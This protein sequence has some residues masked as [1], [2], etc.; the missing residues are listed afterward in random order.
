MGNT[1]FIKNVWYVAGWS[2][3]LAPGERLSRTFLNKPVVLWR[4]AEGKVSA[5]EDR[6][7]HRAMPLSE[8]FVDGEVIRCPYHGMEFGADGR[9]VKIP[10]Q[11]QIP[12]A[13][14][15]VHFPLVEHQALLWIWMGDPDKADPAL[16]PDYPWHD[17]PQWAWRST[18]MLVKGNWQLLVDNLMDLSHLPYIHARTIGGNPELHFGTPTRSEKTPEGVR[19]TRRMPGSVPPP[20][21]VDAKGFTGLVDRWQEIAFEP[22]L[23]RIHTGA[24]DAGTGAYDGRRDHGLSMRGFHAITPETERTTHYFWSIATNVLDNGTPGKVYEQ[25]AATFREDLT[26][27][28]LQQI[29]NDAEPNRPMLDIASDV[30][31]RHARQVIARLLREEAA[32]P[33]HAAPA[34]NAP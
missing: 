29:R 20:T 28:E 3:E 13:A 1:P 2:S 19:V 32:P 26:V 14:K 34:G 23:V 12:S 21:Y 11:D 8:G 24:C 6:C 27:I 10:A 5:L 4:S 22:V 17:D 33:A 16:V 18:R 15:V 30:G 7:V 31:G 25:T 9:C